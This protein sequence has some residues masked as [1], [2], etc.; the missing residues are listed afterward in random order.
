MSAVIKVHTENI[1]LSVEHYGCPGARSVAQHPELT[2]DVV[3]GKAIAQCT[4][5]K[6]KIEISLQCLEESI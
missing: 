3:R 1:G 4:K 6:A 2:I 5:C